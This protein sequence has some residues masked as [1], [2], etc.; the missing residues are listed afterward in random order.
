[1]YGEYDVQT[2]D[3]VIHELQN[4]NNRTAY[5]ESRVGIPSPGHFLHVLTVF[6]VVIQIYCQ[7]MNVE[8]LPIYPIILV[9]FVKCNFSSSYSSPKIASSDPLEFFCS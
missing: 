5:L 1:M 7:S 3:G 9:S 2:T 4:L 6:P 8:Y